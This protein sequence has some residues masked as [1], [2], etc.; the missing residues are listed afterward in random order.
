MHV[1]LIWRKKV[2]EA[3]NVNYEGYHVD[4]MEF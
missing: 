3:V 1:K 4:L 2:E